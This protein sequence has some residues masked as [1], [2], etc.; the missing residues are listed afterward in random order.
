MIAPVRLARVAR[1]L[2]VRAERLHEADRLEPAGLRRAARELRERGFVLQLRTSRRAGSVVREVVEWLVVELEH[3]A[4]AGRIGRARDRVRSGAV[5]ACTVRVSGRGGLAGGV[6]P[7]ACV[8]R[9]VDSLRR[10]PVAD[11]R[12][13][14]QRQLRTEAARRRARRLHGVHCEVAA[15]TS[16]DG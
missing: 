9:P 3:V 12:R 13:R 6:R 16:C 7:A 14:L 8:P 5:R 1:M 11:R 10:E 4:R 15:R 2:V